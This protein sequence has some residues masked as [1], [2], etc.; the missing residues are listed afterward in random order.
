[1]RGAGGAK[2]TPGSVEFLDTVEP[3][4]EDHPQTPPLSS[5]LDSMLGG[6]FTP[7]SEPP[8]ADAARD[9]FLKRCMEEH[10]QSSGKLDKKRILKAAGKVGIK[11]PSSCGMKGKGSFTQLAA[12]AETVALEIYVQAKF[13]ATTTP[14]GGSASSSS[15]TVDPK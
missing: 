10:F 2:R 14:G 3:D 1:M 7:A 6:I 9:E 13:A 8:V 5:A 12:F 15:S 11:A 4:D